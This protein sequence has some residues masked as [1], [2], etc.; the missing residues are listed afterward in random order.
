MTQLPRAGLIDGIASILFPKR[1]EVQLRTETLPTGEV[2][3]D[4]AYFIDGKEVPAEL[5]S[6]EEKQQI[7]GYRVVLDGAAQRG[8]RHTQG[9]RTRL[10]KKKAAEFLLQLENEGIAIRTKDGKR[11][12]RI[13]QVRP[14]VRLTLHP[15]DK[16][17]IAS[18]LVTTEG[19]IVP[20]PADIV[21][22]RNDGGWFSVG[23]DLLKVATTGTTLDK[24]LIQEGSDGTANGGLVPRVLK[25]IQENEKTLGGVERN[26]VLKP[27]SVFGDKTDHQARVDGDSNSISV[28]KS[29]VFTDSEGRKYPK[30]LEHLERLAKE[31]ES[32]DRVDSGWIEITSAAIESHRLAIQELELMLGGLASIRGPDIPRVLSNLTKAARGESGWQTPWAVYF[33]QAVKDSHRLI[34][35]VADVKFRLNIV[36]CDGR[37]LLELSPIYNHERFR[38][39]HDEVRQAAETGIEWVRKKDAWIK[40]DINKHNQIEGGAKLFDLRRTPEGFSFPASD[41]EKVLGLFSTLGSLEHSAAYSEFLIKLAD[42]TQIEDVPLPSSKRPE[43]VF[44]EYQK[45]GYNWLAFLHQ[46]GLNGILADDMGLGKTLQTLAVIQRAKELSHSNLP[47][48]IICPT[49]VISNWRSEVQKFFLG[50]EATLYTGPNRARKLNLIKTISQLTSVNPVTQLVIT[51]FD[52][53]RLDREQ[54]G[55]VRWLYVVVDEGHHIKN[56]NADRTKAIKTINGQHKLVLTGTPI[57]NNLLELWSLVDFVMPGF[58]GSRPEFQRL[59]GLPNGKVNWDAV[60]KGALPL[61]ARVHPFILRRLKET[62]AKDL[63][64][65]LVIDQKAELS[66]LQ[67]DLYQRATQSDEF[68]RLAESVTAKGV[69]QSKV[70]IISTYTRLRGIC[71]HPAIVDDRLAE[72]AIRCEDSGKLEALQELME[73]VMEG[74]HRAL[75]FCQ[76]TKMLD[77]IERF[78]AKWNVRYLRL[79]GSTASTARGGMVDEFNGNAAINCFLISTKAGGTGLNLT[80]ADTVIFYD[81]DWNPANDRQ[82][83]DRAYRIGQTKTVTVYRLLSEGTIEEKIIERQA[84]KQTLADRIIGEDEEG[85]KD[86]KPDELL[87]LFKL[88]LPNAK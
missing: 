79:D 10:S 88:S 3:I 43:I 13:A 4:P 25:A 84:L 35:T 32:F 30:S 36:E 46:F 54:L 34:E 75:L 67:V 62:V 49:S 5:V 31:G 14:E 18:E 86:L 66:P 51:S 74:E 12:P 11:Q 63:P 61:K 69:A 57:Q 1:L 55:S 68:Q 29:L 44:R 33:S 48:L 42:F 9:K 24:L 83:Q 47:V 21:Q 52:V 26:D 72:K 37:S 28:A 19:V 82:A 16:L 41:R 71:N 87:A 80:G 23:D 8:H 20:K 27:L 70:Q 7:L 50:C 81:H 56:P 85:F 15:D 58:L 78:F 59:Y 6:L 73:E 77:I 53:A 40:T 64:A 2:Q 60:L 76:S 22:I 39:N 65:K 38:L 45:H 17:S